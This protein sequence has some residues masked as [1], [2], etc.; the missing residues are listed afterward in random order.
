MS[1]SNPQCSVIAL[2]HLVLTVAS[3]AETIQFYS[4]VLGMHA[5][6]FKTADA[7]TRWA[8]KF[9]STKIN[10]HEKG[11]EFEPKANHPTPGS[12]D[13]CFLTD[14]TLDVW[15][16]HL[17]TQNVIV[18]EGPI[19]RAGAMGPLRSLYIRDPDQNLI[20]VSIQS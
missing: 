14:V 7:K 4:H 5:E 17:A 20:E 6:Q 13:L 10:L 15:M 16:T 8:L 18:E 9:G 11:R 1:Q 2:D 3:I 12:A 19:A